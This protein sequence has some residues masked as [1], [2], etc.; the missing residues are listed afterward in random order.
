LNEYDAAMPPRRPSK[1]APSPRSNKTP[2]ARLESRARL[3]DA[4]LVLF[5]SQG[6][7]ATST[8]AIAAQANA[9]LAA[10]PYY[11]GG[12]EGLYRAV[13][14]HIAAEINTH[15]GAERDRLMEEMRKAPFSSPRARAALH[16]ILDT[17]V[18]VI[19]SPEAARW[20]PF[21]LRE[22]IQP[23]SA[24]HVLYGGFMEPMHRVL[25]TLLAVIKGGSPDEAETCLQ[26]F[27][28]VG[29]VIIFRAAQKAVLTRLGWTRLETGELNQI[30]VV[31]HDNLDRLIASERPA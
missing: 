3:I 9:N 4:A 10:I 28:L 1:R 11:F 16:H 27:T 20:A 30:R 24:F 12:K 2:R 23:T 7:E 13:A 26:V 29:Q 17:F 6:F 22:Q 31:L 19:L 25:S 5:A 18:G 14:E 21:I 8:R 15:V